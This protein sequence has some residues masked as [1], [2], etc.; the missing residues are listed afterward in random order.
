M[1]VLGD[2]SNH[3]LLSHKPRG[4]G[5]RMPRAEHDLETVAICFASGHLVAGVKMW[6]LFIVRQLAGTRYIWRGGM[7]SK[8]GWFG[9]VRQVGRP[10]KKRHP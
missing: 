3:S 9:L 8:M 5:G 2:V 4:D 7:E 10:G 1:W 6:G